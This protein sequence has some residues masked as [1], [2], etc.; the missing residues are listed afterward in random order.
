MCALQLTQVQA[1]RL[2]TLGTRG[3]PGGKRKQTYM[4]GDKIQAVKRLL[5]EGKTQRQIMMEVHISNE[6]ITK[7]RRGSLN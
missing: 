6:S 3:N 2:Q 5:Q 1:A 7:I 4:S